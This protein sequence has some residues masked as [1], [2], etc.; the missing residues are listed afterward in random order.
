MPGATEIYI[1]YPGQAI[2][3]GKVEYSGLETR[4]EAE[5]DAASRVRNDPTI[6]KIAYYAVKEDGSF[7]SL[8]S[9][10]NPHAAKV[11]K[12]RSALDD[13]NPPS[14]GVPRKKPLF[15]RIRAIFEED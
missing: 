5:A 7:R 1:C 2:R 9:F 14:E 12:R 8:Y 10:E 6:A 15:Q 13:L 3:D 4:D 11:P